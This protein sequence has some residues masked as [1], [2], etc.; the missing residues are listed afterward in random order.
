MWTKLSLLNTPV[1]PVFLLIFA[2]IFAIKSSIFASGGINGGD[3]LWH[4]EYGKFISEHH[5][6]P[7]VDWLTWT[8]TGK[9]YLVTQ[10]LGQLLVT[11]AFTA[12]GYQATAF[13]VAV[14]VCLTFFFSWRTAAL[15]VP[16][17][18]LSLLIALFCTQQVLTLNARPQMF[19]I[20]AF[21]ALVWVLA[22]W[23]ERKAK[24]AL[25][26]M[27][28]IM[29]LWVNLHG[30]YIVG[31]L[32]MAALGGGAWLVTFALTK[33]RFIESVK[34]HLPLA[35]ACFG[36]IFAVLLNPYGWHAFEYVYQI[37]QLETTKLGII[38]EW[39]ATSLSTGNGQTFFFV[40]FA[41]I[42]CIALAKTK[43]DLKS[44]LGF[45][46]CVYFGLSADRQTYFASL[47]MVPFLAKAFRSTRVH[48][49]LSAVMKVKANPL[50]SAVVL[51]VAAL[52]AVSI[53]S[54][55]KTFIEKNVYEVY[56]VKALDYIEANHLKG[57]LFNQVEFGGYIESRGHK[58][59]IDGRLDLFGDDMTLGTYHALN[60][61]PG[62]EKFLAQYKPDLFILTNKAQLKQ[63]LLMSS[64]HKLIY[65]DTFHCV[66]ERTT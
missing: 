51:V 60:G 24:W 50:T 37:S 61:E 29:A 13:L 59:F 38:A 5:S 18:V 3:F 14:V 32:Y 25:F 16:N 33:G 57:K 6:L 21:S 30:S 62:W 17:Q 43:P 46:G 2:F 35:I 9:S 41:T 63:M 56:P 7:T 20:A 53:H 54:S 34:A 27:P 23:F 15:Y 48:D 39:A 55:S 8:N 65:E 12:G 66:I 58:S 64:G 44:L 19:G 36:A 42:V 22:V 1:V 52:L 26:A 47:A 45:I 31:V 10:W 40:T 4:I 49:S 11:L 28:V